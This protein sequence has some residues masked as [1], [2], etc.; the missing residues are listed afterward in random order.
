MTDSSKNK[1]FL[2]PEKKQ[3][4]KPNSIKKHLNPEELKAH[5]PE[6]LIVDDNIFNVYSLKL[7]IEQHFKIPTAIA[8][9]GEEAIMK[10]N[11]RIESGR[12]PFTLILTDINM[13]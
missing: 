4:N 11:E 7:L 6:I 13:P 9:S 3:E 1:I 2:I 12:G 10:F 8:Y 5:D